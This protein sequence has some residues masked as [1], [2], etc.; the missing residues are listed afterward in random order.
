MCDVPNV[1]QSFSKSFLSAGIIDYHCDP[2]CCRIH[3]AP[4]WWCANMNH[5]H[6]SWSTF[7]HTWH[8]LLSRFFSSNPELSGPRAVIL[9]FFEIFEKRNFLDPSYSSTPP[10]PKRTKSGTTTCRLGTIV[11]PVAWHRNCRS[12][13]VKQRWKDWR[14]LWG[15]RPDCSRPVLR[16]RI[17]RVSDV[18][19]RWNW[20]VSGMTGVGKLG[21]EMV[22]MMTP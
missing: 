16:R 18:G 11:P 3:H 14:P 13:Q 6:D 20:D 1:V 12:C 7:V 8:G 15:H 5:Y 19:C 4:S 2:S 17:L 9:V 10:E 21:R 22:R